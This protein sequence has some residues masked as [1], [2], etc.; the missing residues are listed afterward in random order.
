MVIKFGISRQVFHIFPNIK[1]HVNPSSGSQAD[2]C[3]QTD[4]TTDR[5]KDGRANSLTQL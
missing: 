5:E 3:G 4:E 2:M 1:F